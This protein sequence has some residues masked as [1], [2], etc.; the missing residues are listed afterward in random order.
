MSGTAPLTCY[1][2]TID[3][4]VVANLAGSIG[5]AETDILER[6]I[7]QIAQQKPKIVV[8]DLD[9]L[10]F[11]NSLG[12][13]AFIK[14]HQSIKPH[15]GVVRIARPSSFVMGVIKAGKMESVLPIFPTVEAAIKG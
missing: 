4:A 7:A 10:G 3:G 1:V 6:E 2:Q 9:R 5:I 11:M 8:L 12:M 13:G 15:G 14:L